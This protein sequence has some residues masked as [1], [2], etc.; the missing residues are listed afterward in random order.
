VPRYSVKAAQPRNA[1]PSRRAWLLER[2]R[3]ADGPEYGDLVGE[4]IAGFP[5][6]TRY[7]AGVR[8]A[9]SVRQ[10]LWDQDA[11]VDHDGSVWL[12]PRGWQAA[13][14]SS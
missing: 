11:T 4:M 3:E 14:K 1:H 12:T 13:E 8:A 2:L 7:W 6:K 5:E 9:R 10:L